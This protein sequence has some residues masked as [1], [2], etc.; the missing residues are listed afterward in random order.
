VAEQLALVAEDW[1]HAVFVRQGLKQIGS[2]GGSRWGG[3]LAS[4]LRA[5]GRSWHFAHWA[6]EP[7]KN[8]IPVLYIP[9]AWAK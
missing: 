2:P 7:E 1:F 3:P 8:C 5:K 6:T 9:T 4:A